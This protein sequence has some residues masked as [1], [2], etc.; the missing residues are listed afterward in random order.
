[1]MKDDDITPKVLLDHMRAMEDR[2]MKEIQ[3]IRVD[4]QS[5]D[6]RL[7]RV[8][9]CLD[10]VEKKLTLISTQIQNIDERLDVIEIEELPRRVVAVEAKTR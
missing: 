7:C 4:V 5:I 1:M 6:Q 8:E 3:G 9:I 10:R 2:I